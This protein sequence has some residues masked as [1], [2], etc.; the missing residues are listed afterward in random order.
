L[1]LSFKRLIEDGTDDDVGIVSDFFANAL[2]GRRYL[3]SRTPTNDVGVEF[4]RRN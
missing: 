4:R 1:E 3:E 2:A